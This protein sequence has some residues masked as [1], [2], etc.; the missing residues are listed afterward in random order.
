MACVKSWPDPIIIVHIKAPKIITKFGLWAH[1]MW[2]KKVPG[3]N[4]LEEK[5]TGFMTW[6]LQ[7][8]DAWLIGN[9]NTA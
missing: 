7:F 8:I 2:V 5:Q 3:S 9:D 4:Q 1:E 6:Q